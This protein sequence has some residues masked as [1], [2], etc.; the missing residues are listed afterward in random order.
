MILIVSGIL[1]LLGL[2]MLKIFIVSGFSPHQLMFGKN[3]NLP[4][5]MNDQLSAGYSTNP[6]IIEHLKALHSSL[7]SFMKAESSAKLRNALRKQTRHTREHFDL[8]QA[9][10]Y[11]RNNDIKWKGPGKIAGQDGS[12]VFIRHG[13]F[14]IK[15]HC[16]RIQIADSLPDTIPQDND[17]QLHSQALSQQAA[18]QEMNSIQLI[19]KKLPL[20]M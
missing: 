16:S 3:V 14:Y 19:Q 17:S 8:G 9:V 13:D 12:V 10:Y 5:T 15:V 20:T 1:L 7:E 2:L 6:L 4:S 11:K 18:I